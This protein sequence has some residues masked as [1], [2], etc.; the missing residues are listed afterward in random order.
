MTSS[1]LMA[2]SLMRRR[3]SLLPAA[4][5]AA[6]RRDRNA[7]SSSV[8]HSRALQLAGPRDALTA[9]NA[10][11]EAALKAV[12]AKG[13]TLKE[14]ARAFRNNGLVP[15]YLETVPNFS[16]I[17]STDYMPLEASRVT[18]TER[19]PV[20]PRFPRSLPI[21]RSTG[22]APSSSISR[23]PRTPLPN[24]WRRQT[25]RLIATHPGRMRP[26]VVGVTGPPFPEGPPPC[27]RCELSRGARRS[28]LG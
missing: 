21:S 7:R 9:A 1:T 25:P 12:G 24:E 20:R 6:N 3:I 19:R 10:A 28:Q 22:P 16:R 13:N 5:R 4:V 27:G 15:G 8:G 14:L 17:C 23:R 2:T 11:V 18:L 26:R